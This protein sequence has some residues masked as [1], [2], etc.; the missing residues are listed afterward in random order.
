[1]GDAAAKNGF[2]LIRD[3]RAANSERLFS[4]KNPLP[5]YF[6]RQEGKIYGI[7]PAVT[8]VAGEVGQ[9]VH[10]GTVNAADADLIVQVGA[11]GNA[12]GAYLSDDWATRWP[13]TAMTRLMWPYTV[14]VPSSC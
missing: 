14:R 8:D 6:I 3:L 11:G 9:G 10:S 12:G 2:D 7:L 1:M 4:H 13:V 5:P